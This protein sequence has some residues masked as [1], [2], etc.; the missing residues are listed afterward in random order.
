MLFA[1]VASSAGAAQSA[2]L[3]K[4]LSGSA[5]VVRGSSVLTV[6]LGQR[7]FP[8]DRIATASTSYVGITLRDDT[9]ISLGPNSEFA[10]REFDFNPSSYAGGL[11]ASFI[12]GTARVVTGII[13]K[14]APERL[15]FTTATATIGIRGT[16]FIVDLG[17]PQ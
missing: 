17:D 5:T 6:K 4:T 12:K 16:D 7:V 13:G 15:K 14:H 8:G 9:R 1:T 2:G 10:I 11:F 3:V